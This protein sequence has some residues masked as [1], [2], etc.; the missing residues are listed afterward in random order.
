MDID[1][2]WKYHLLHMNKALSWELNMLSA[3]EKLYL[4]PSTDKS[5]SSEDE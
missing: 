3:L 5:W 4:F 2:Q 1:N